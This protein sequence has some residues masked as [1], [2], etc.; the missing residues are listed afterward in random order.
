[1]GE[2]GGLSRRLIRAVELHGMR[3]L[4]KIELH[5]AEVKLKRSRRA[6]FSQGKLSLEG[7]SPQSPTSNA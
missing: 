7:A 5:L 6:R 1:M 3:S 2:E 4:E